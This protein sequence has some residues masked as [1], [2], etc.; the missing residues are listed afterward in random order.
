MVPAKKMAARVVLPGLPLCARDAGRG[1]VRSSDG[2]RRAA[3]SAVQG[4]GRNK[5]NR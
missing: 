3:E 2:W 5:M 4:A 1:E